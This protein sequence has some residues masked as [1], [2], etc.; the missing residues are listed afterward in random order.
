M[1]IQE[2]TV[3]VE[4]VHTEHPV[5]INQVDVD[6]Q[7]VIVPSV[8]SLLLFLQ[9]IHFN[10]INFLKIINGF[11]NN[12]CGVIILDVVEL[13]PVD[14]L[15]EKG[16]TETMFV[17]KIVPKF[18]SGVPSQDIHTA[19]VVRGDS[20]PSQ[21]PAEATVVTTTED[22]GPTDAPVITTPEDAAPVVTDDSG[23]GQELRSEAP[24][25]TTTEDTG[26]VV[27]DDGPS[28]DVAT[29][30]PVVTTADK[31]D[32]ELNVI[33]SEEDTNTNTVVEHSN[34]SKTTVMSDLSSSRTDEEIAT[35][36]ADPI[37]TVI[38]PVEEPSKSQPG[39]PRCKFF[40][41]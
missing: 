37:I 32:S 8:F 2:A 38:E 36:M 39:T 4:N 10:S 14:V 31:S 9:S 12:C 19:P 25:V 34:S 24:M 41:L 20:G 22:T 13:T 21:A 35:G 23:P 18:P 5:N 3:T 30:A 26:R 7:Y 16:E 40:L 33:S 15:N 1:S 6:V 28:Q 11:L 29:E 27:T 17:E